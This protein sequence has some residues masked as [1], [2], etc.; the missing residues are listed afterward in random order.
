LVL[1]YET[2]Q[3]RESELRIRAFVEREPIDFVVVDEIHHTKQRDAKHMS[4][5]RRLVTAMIAAAGECNTGLY[6]LGMSAT[7]V[8]NNLYEGRS[9][10]DLITGVA[11]DDLETR[12]TT[13]N[14][15]QMHQHL[16]RLGIRWMPEYD[17]VDEEV[18]I[19]VDCSDYIDDIRALG[20]SG[21]P[22]ALE[23]ILT[24]ARLPVIREHIKPKTLIYTHYVDRVVKLLRDALQGDGWNVGFFIG[25]DKSG[26]DG[27]LRGDVEVLI[28]SSAI[29]TGVDGLQQVCNRLIINVLPWT[30]ADYEQLK[31][32]IYRQGQTS[33]TVEIIIPITFAEV[34]GQ[35]WS[36][37]QSK[38]DRL[39]YKKSI[40]DAAVDG[41]VPEGHLRTPA[42]AYLDVM[43]W[44]ERLESGEV[45]TLARQPIVVP[46]S[47]EPVEVKRR[48]AKYG[49]FS[50]INRSWNQRQSATTHEVLAADPE[51]WEHY[52]TLYREA[53]QSWTVVPFEEMIRWCN[54]RSDLVI[55]D[56]GC[57]EAQIC[58]A[59]S[60]R[61][62]VYSFDH[63]AINDDVTA[64]DIAHVLCKPITVG[65]PRRG[66][67][68]MELAV[69]H[70]SPMRLT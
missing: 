59:V 7:P 54:E 70:Q 32:R 66:L 20:R 38:M 1:N 18:R 43:R 56:F 19:E 48:V 65:K 46:L 36:W 58:E 3:Q 28:A 34:G 64:C 49:D 50:K 45:E 69:E 60:D 14:C 24:R 29:G 63:V 21:T 5:R 30:A 55:G 27:F 4:R 2:F 68:D 15:M 62:T 17:F 37:C 16:T 33:K 39:K 31:G 6:V 9:L 44:L 13:S 11:H 26:L 35:R 47:D 53:R 8:I 41:V 22:L 51:A 42:Q 57:G 25:E 52:H 23:Q 40:A 10:V 12:A 67:V 61:H